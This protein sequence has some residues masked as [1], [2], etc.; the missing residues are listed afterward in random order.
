MTGGSLTCNSGD[1]IYVTNTAC[2]IYMNGVD[3]TNN[4]TDGVFPE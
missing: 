1:T 4:D 2:L 3:I